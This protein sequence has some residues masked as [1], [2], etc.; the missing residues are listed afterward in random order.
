MILFSMISLFQVQKITPSLIKEADKLRA[1]NISLC[2][3]CI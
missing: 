2:I 1:T 3:K